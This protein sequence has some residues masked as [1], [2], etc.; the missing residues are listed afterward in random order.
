MPT[1]AAASALSRDY[2]DRVALTDS[3]DDPAALAEAIGVLKTEASDFDALLSER[4]KTA[5][6]EIGTAM[7][8]FLE[9]CDFHRLAASGT[10]AEIARLQNAGILP[11]ASAR[12]LNRRQQE[13][14]RQSAL[15]QDILS[16]REILREQKF[17]MNLPLS[18]LTRHPERFASAAGE[19]VFVQGAIDLLLIMPDGSVR[20]YDYKTDRL[21]GSRAEMEQTLRE[22]HARQLSYYV[23]AVEALCGKPPACVLLYSLAL[24]GTVAL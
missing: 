9:I 7:H 13:L 6:T 11:D 22:K 10:D 14:F 16:A 5:P 1:K 8:L 23:K 12:L 21:H 18:A 2:L 15:M 20:L 24:G 19:T 4:K 3:T 17:G